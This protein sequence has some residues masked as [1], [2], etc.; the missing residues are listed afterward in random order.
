MSVRAAG[1]SAA[2]LALALLPV[3][4]SAQQSPALEGRVR[5]DE[6]AAVYAATALLLRDGRVE[7]LAETDRLGFFRITDVVPGGYRLR[8]TRLGHASTEM[9][10]AVTLG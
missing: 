6:G 1:R 2:L 10:V 3:G 8:V 5:D 7:R 4:G 9:D